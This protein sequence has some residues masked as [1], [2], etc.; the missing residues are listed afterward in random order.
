MNEKISELLK[1]N[2]G[3]VLSKQLGSNVLRYQLKK[4]ADKGELI[5][6]KRGLYRDAQLSSGA[7]WS[8][9][10]RIIPSGVLCMFTAWQ[11][12]ELTTHVSSQIHI[13]V[14]HKQKVVLP[15]YPPIKLYYWSNQYQGMAK[16]ENR[17]NGE[18]IIIYDLEKSVCDAVKFR[19]KVGIDITAEVLKNY[20]K[21]KDRNLDALM[22]Y[23]K[24]LRISD[25]MTQ[26]LNM[27]L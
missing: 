15:D 11:Y 20:I 6:V 23:A 25:T 8:Q 4:M 7:D 5:M 27:M 18:N 12:F 9:V 16:T 19:N 2:N 24:V 10:C 3:Y 22:K 14:P 1:A 21:R 17:Y 13:A 26:Y